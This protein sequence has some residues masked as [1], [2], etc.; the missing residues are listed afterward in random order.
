MI[1]KRPRLVDPF[2]SIALVGVDPVG[3]TGMVGVERVGVA[4]FGLAGANPG[5]NGRR[6]RRNVL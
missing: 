6:G 3:Y 4:V 5:A 2:A 1:P